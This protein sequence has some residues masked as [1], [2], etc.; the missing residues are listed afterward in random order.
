[1]TERAWRALGEH[2]ARQ[3]ADRERVDAQIDALAARLKDP[4]RIPVRVRE[5]HQAG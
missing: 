4:D 5:W 1:M 3:R 2:L